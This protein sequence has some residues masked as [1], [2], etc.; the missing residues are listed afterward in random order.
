MNRQWPAVGQDPATHQ[1]LVPAISTLPVAP[2]S[3]FTPIRRAVLAR[4]MRFSNQLRNAAF[5]K[6]LIRCEAT[7]SS[8]IEQLHAPSRHIALAALDSTSQS[9]GS[10][11]AD[12]IKTVEVALEHADQLTVASMLTMHQTLMHDSMPHHAGKTRTEP[13]WTGSNSPA[14][15]VFVPPDP[16]ELPAALAD[17]VSFMQRTDMDPLTQAAIAHAQFET[18]QPHTDGNGRTGRA[19]V[20]AVL[21]ARGATPH[22]PVPLSAGLLATPREYFDA[23]EAYRRGDVSPIVQLFV[24]ASLRALDNADQLYENLQTLQAE[25]YATGKRVTKNLKAVTEL[26]TSQ[27]AF[28]AHMVEQLGVPTASAYRIINHLV[29][30]GV[31]RTEQKIHGQSVWTVSP[32][33]RILDTFVTRASRWLVS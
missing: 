8:A 32:L 28:T 26:C 25:I 20:T 13:A 3:T 18:L 10:M 23:L 14:T 7:A 21:R 27:P 15:A 30:H 2:A 12:N 24:F 11:V 33:N 1:A 16:A 9:I 17:L 19:I 6:L 29:D 31:L 4:M 22:L 5:Q